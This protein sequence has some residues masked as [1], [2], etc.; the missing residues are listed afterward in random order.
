H[1]Y[2][3]FIKGFIEIIAGIGLK[4]L[5]EIEANKKI[6]ESEERYK[7]IVQ[8]TSDWVWEIDEHG[9][10]SYCSDRVVDIL[11]YNVEEI[12][13]KARSDLMTQ[14][15]GERFSRIFQNIV[16]SKNSIKDLENWCMHKDG[17]M[18]YLLTTGFPILDEIGNVIGY[19]GA[20]K[21]ITEL[22]REKEKLNLLEQRSFAWLENS[23]VCTKIVDL[24]FNL[25]YMS[26]AGVKG[27]KIDDITPYYGKPYPFYFYPESFKSTMSGNMIKAKV[28]GEV[29]TQ[30]APVVDVT[31]NEIW[32]H[33][34]IVP[35]KDD[36]GVVE[37]LIIVSLD[38]TK[39]KKA[40]DTLQKQEEQY[41]T[42]INSVSEGIIL[43]ESD[44]RIV[45]WNTSAERIFGITAKEIV[46]R[47]STEIIWNTIREDGSVFPAAEHPSIITLETGKPCNNIVMGVINL[48]G[49][50]T[51]ININ[52]N[53]LFKQ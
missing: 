19:R 28:T 42:V 10:Y 37:Y 8:N 45:T 46:G 15:E 14:V 43:Q 35:V 20:D 30:E 17:H 51:W 31:G 23:P 33:S 50:I 6:K 24:D 25:Q 36:Y 13:G 12:L 22:K 16:A 38:T 49:A 47:L 40:E 2:L 18:V 7:T 52:T 21:D 1:H 11:G 5:K 39:R 29:I 41:R 44:G 48:E 9:K 27:L 4:N 26:S 53:P 3:D 34:T 32:F